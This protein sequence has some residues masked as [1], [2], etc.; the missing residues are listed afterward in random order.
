MARESAIDPPLSEV[1]LFPKVS[2]PAVSRTFPCEKIVE[3]LPI[4]M[5]CVLPTLMMLRAMPAPA[6]P[7]VTTFAVVEARAVV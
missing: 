2:R 3:P 1:A 4:V 7:K 6:K 5:P